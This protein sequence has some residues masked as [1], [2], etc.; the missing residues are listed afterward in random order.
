MRIVPNMAG[1]TAITADQAG[2]FSVKGGMIQS[3]VGNVGFNSCGTSNLGVSTLIKKSNKDI[4]TIAIITEKS[5]MYWRTMVGKKRAFLKSFNM[6][7]IINVPR[8]NSTDM[9]N[10]FE[11]SG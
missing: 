1:N 8:N 3:R 11:V 2:F 9:R 5:L 10:I 6:V 4:L 7:E